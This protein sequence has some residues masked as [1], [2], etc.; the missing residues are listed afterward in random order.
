MNKDKLN[1]CFWRFNGHTSLQSVSQRPKFHYISA[2]KLTHYSDIIMGAMASQIT[3]VSIVYSTVCWVPDQRKHQNSASLAFVRGIHRWPVNSPYKGPVTRKMSFD[4]V[5]MCESHFINEFIPSV[6]TYAFLHKNISIV[7]ICVMTDW[8]S[9][10]PSL[11]VAMVSLRFKGRRFDI[12][13]HL[14]K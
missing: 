2:S 7:E 6:L 4:G 13:L 12:T 10:G 11:L 9:S 8:L 14:I 1:I 3:T 5:I